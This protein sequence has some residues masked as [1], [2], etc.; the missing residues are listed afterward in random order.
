MNAGTSPNVNLFG[1]KNEP[2]DVCV[3]HDESGDYG[4]S[5]WVFTGLLW[6][7]KEDVSE[8]AR[9]LQAIR[10]QENYWRE[11]HL[12]SLPKSF[13]GAYGAK[14]RVA[15][16]WFEKWSGELASKTW[17]NVLAVHRNHPRYEHKRFTKEFHAYNRFTL[18]ALKAGLAW[19]FQ[20]HQQVRLW[21]YSDNKTR[22]PGGVLGDGVK[23]DNFE[24]YITD[25]LTEDTVS[26]KGP[27]VCLEARPECLYFPSDSALVE[28]KNELLCL[29]DLLLGSVAGAIYPNTKRPTKQWFARRAARIIQ[30]VRRKPWEQQM[31]LHRRFSVSYFPRNDGLIYTDGPIGILDKEA[32]QFSFGGF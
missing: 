17:F 25:K 15:R 3:F 10:Q 28:P 16:G 11:I 2:M 6:V 12:N 22:R 20:N 9:S 31:G 8:V 13:S 4:H 21:I 32:G 14:A 7:R 27:R 19:H 18:M 26:Y 5:P 24:D 1:E 29:C 23:T 30:D